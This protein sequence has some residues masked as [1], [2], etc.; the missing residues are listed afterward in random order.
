MTKCLFLALCSFVVL[1]FNILNF[2]HTFKLKFSMK[3]FIFGAFVLFC[4]ISYSQNVVNIKAEVAGNQ[5]L[6][7]YDLIGSKNDMFNVQ[8][9]CSS[10]NY[11]SP[12][13]FVTG[14][15]G[16]NIKE[17]S[18]KKVYWDF[19]KEN[20]NNMQNINFKIDATISSK[21]VGSSY[22]VIFFKNGNE[23]NS[24][25]IEIAL[26][27]IKYKK[28]E[29]IDGPTITIP[30][31]D[32]L[33]I[34]YANGTKDIINTAN[35]NTVQPVV[36]TPSTSTDICTDA[37]MDANN[38]YVGKNCGSGWTTATTIIAT[39]ILGIIPA[40]ACSS[41][42]PQTQNLGFP[43]SELMKDPNYSRCYREQAHSI[44]KKKI[45]RNFGIG[46]GIWLALYIL[47]TM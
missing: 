46:T 1:H 16:G 23:I 3:N 11:S 38:F 4:S 21:S 36:E 18:Y 40:V 27:E 22:D 32:V 29:N 19:S 8:V 25:I 15:V 13:K 45:W 37:I 31:S 39:P 20:T 47:G 7:T 5:V 6:I 2:A 28:I 10:D 24:K 14:D 42:E 33:M 9:F 35:T 26:Y 44:K 12:L 41:S 43:K 17:G 30:K 34:K